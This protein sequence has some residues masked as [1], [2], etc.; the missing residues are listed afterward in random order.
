MSELVAARPS[1]RVARSIGAV[2]AGV[3]T[4]IVVVGAIDAAM[5]AAGVF[6]AMFEPMDDRQWA[7]ALANRVVM[8]VVG[9]FITAWLAPSRPLR[10]VLI[11]GGIETLLSGL[12]VA[13]NW[14]KPE[15]GPHWFGV[16]VAISCVPLALLGGVLRAKQVART[17]S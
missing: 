10:H 16:G 12:F 13:V 4:N 15:Y 11:L 9:G 5:R 17:R 3:L 8:A 14:N 2:L 1:R 7:I 6:P